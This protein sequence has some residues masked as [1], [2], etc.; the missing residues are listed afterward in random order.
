[1]KIKILYLSNAEWIR[2]HDLNELPHFLTDEHLLK[3]SWN[4]VNL[5]EDAGFDCEPAKIGGYSQWNGYQFFENRCGMFAT[6]QKL[7]DEQW[8][9]F[10][11]AYDKAIQKE[12]AEFYEGY[13]LN[14][15]IC[16]VE[17]DRHEFWEEFPD[18]KCNNE[19]CEKCMQEFEPDEIEDILDEKNHLTKGI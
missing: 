18:G 2:Q 15:K 13:D 14:C 5:L 1:M 17:I 11:D 12:V 16:G 3:L 7:S 4:V 19:V 8:Q 10:V 6:K 9:V